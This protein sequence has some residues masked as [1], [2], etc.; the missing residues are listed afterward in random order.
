M[1]RP[2]G[3]IRTLPGQS[4]YYEFG[5]RMM[6]SYEA[7]QEEKVP[8]IYVALPQLPKIDVLHIYMLVG[9]Q[10][11]C[12]MNIA[13]FENGDGW[14]LRCWDG[15]KRSSRWWIVCSKPVSYPPETIRMRGFQ[16]FRYTA[17]LW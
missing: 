13:G 10:I 2:T 5:D 14:Q 4:K 3:I 15:I 11:I 17:D 1:E 9:G 12:R 7:L 8:A 16:G 6:R